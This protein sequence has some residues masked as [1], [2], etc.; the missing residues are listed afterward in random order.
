MST[1]VKGLHHITLCPGR[2]QD[3]LDFFTRVLGQRLVKQT[4][5]LDGNIP[6]YHFYYGNIDA[7]IGSIITTFP[8]A[9]RP[10]RPGSGQVSATSYSVP[11]GTLAFW[12]DHFDRC[13]ARHGTVEE[14][15]GEPCIEVRHPAGMLIELVEQAGD[16]R[17]PWTTT[18]ISADVATRGFSGV[19]MSVREVGEQEEFFTCALGARKVGVDGAYHRFEIPGDGPARII[20]LHHEPDRPPGSWT[21][22]A[23]TAHHVAFDVDSDEALARQ[24]AL[25]EELGYTDVSELKDR[26]YFHSIYVRSPGGIL[27]EC[28][29]NPPGG[30][31]Q[32]ESFAELGTKLHLPPWF[33]DQRDAILSMLE[34][35]TVPEENRAS[36][37]MPAAAPA[38]KPVTVNGVTLSRTKPDFVNEKG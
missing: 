34:P 21:F 20:D 7:D 31:Y 10:G 22:G 37:G 36:P 33:E 32:D 24:K 13:G 1:L 8:Y 38:A 11:P 9:R 27:V 28:T 16:C 15:F 12:R 17:R 25:Y 26:Y 19:V 23:G 5:L 6:I 14:R 35:I 30:F 4:V 18:D 3:D 29:S 2:A